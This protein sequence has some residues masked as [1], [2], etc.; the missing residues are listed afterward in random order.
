MGKWLRTLLK[1]LYCI[2]YVL[3]KSKASRDSEIETSSYIR[4]VEEWEK[5]G[6]LVWGYTTVYGRAIAERYMRGA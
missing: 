6:E 1:I 5:T 4:E 2:G 3:A